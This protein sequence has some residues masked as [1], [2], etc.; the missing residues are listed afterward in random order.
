MHFFAALVALLLLIAPLAHAESTG[1]VGRSGKQAGTFC[2]ACHGDGTFQTDAVITGPTSVAASSIHTYT[3][4]ISVSG[5]DAANAVNAG[6]N[7]AAS[8]GVLSSRDSSVQVAMFGGAAEVTHVFPPKDLIANTVSYQFRWE[9]PATTGTYTIYAAVNATN[10]SATES[11]DDPDLATP[12]VVTV[13]CLDPDFDQ[14]CATNPDN[15]P[16]EYNPT[17]SDCDN[18]GV[19]DAC[20]AT[21]AAPACAGLCL[22]SC[23]DMIVDALEECDD[24]VETTTCNSSCTLAT[25]GD[26]VTNATRGEDCDDAGASADCDADCT[27]RECG[28]GVVNQS[29]GEACDTTTNTTLCDIDCTQPLCGDGLTNATT[30]EA[31]DDSGFSAACDADCSLPVC[32]DSVVNAAA[33]E[34]CDDGDA[35]GGDGCSANCTQV[36]AGWACGAAGAACTEVCGDLLRVGTEECDDGGPSASC[37]ADCTVSSCGDGV[38]NAAAGEVCDEG[39][40]VASGGCAGDCAQIFA[41]WYCTAGQACV[42]QCGDN[43]TSGTEVCDSG[44]ESASCDGDCTTPVCGDGRVNSAALET[45]DD[46]D[47]LSDDGCSATCTTEPGWLCPAGGGACSG[48][49]GD[50]VKVASE[51]CDQGAANSD[52]V[53]NACRADCTLPRCGD[54]VTDA[55]E[56]CDEGSANSNT[57]ANRC[58]A[59]CTLPRCGDGIVDGAYGEGC[60]DTNA[61]DGDSCSAS[62]TLELCG[63]GVVDAG[64]QCDDGFAN[65]NATADACRGTCLTAFCGDGVVDTGEACDDGRNNSM[66]PNFCRTSCQPPRCG[67]GIVDSGEDCDGSSSCADD[68]ALRDEGESASGCAATDQGYGLAL[69]AMLGWLLRKR[70]GSRRYFTATSR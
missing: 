69:V 17:Q 47:A 39:G 46:N 16:T 62:C 10:G 55:G 3:V 24:G 58:R 50:G 35:T 11:G 48:T 18:D 29:G 64:E 40:A 2:N 68:C 56:Q 43:I 14:V 25:C 4:T 34:A 57:I 70:Q 51:A 41:G 66:L 38:V 12:L 31:C 26:G 32:G 45:C 52:T 6:F 33:G 9:A 27:T 19:G 53:A 23:G 42:T 21:C 5:P 28:D 65:S 63:N 37:N 7:A 36:E 20:D 13:D 15:C 61:V 67:D 22:G 8:A 60:D 49:C 44:G 1:I 30:G 59:A 54:Q